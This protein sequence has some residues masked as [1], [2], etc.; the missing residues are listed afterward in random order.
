[1]SAESLTIIELSKRLHALG[2]ELPMTRER[3]AF[4]V[5][6]YKEAKRDKPLEVERLERQINIDPIL[7]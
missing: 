5:N 4:Y 7:E 6:L 3:K 1:M 2:Y